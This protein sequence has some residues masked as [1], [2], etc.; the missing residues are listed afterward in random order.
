MVRYRLDDLGWYQF[1]W[2]IQALLKDRVG[3]GV[4]S[5]GGHGDH[6][7]DAWCDGPL[8]F[9]SKDIDTDGPFLFQVK[10]I[11]EA[12][13]V[14]AR[15]A[16]R[17]LDAVRAETKSI[18]RRASAG[19]PLHKQCAHYTLVTNSPVS[20]HDR[21]AA[22]NL[23]KA[24][25]C[26]STVHC[27]C[28]S[29]V[30]DLLD[31][32]PTLRR[33]FP[34]LLSI[35]DLDALLSDVVDREIIQR[36]SAAIAEARDVVPV[37]V[38][39]NAY[40]KAWEVLRKHRFVVLEGPPEMGK[41]A[42]AWM[43]ALA[44]IA[45]GWEGV[46]CDRPDDFFAAYRPGTPQIFIADDAFGR[47]EYDPTRGASWERQLHR[48][49]SRL[50]NSHWLVWTSRKHILERARKQMDLQGLAATF[51][52]PAEVI[53]NASD[54]T[55]REKAL[56]LYRHSKHSISDPRIKD[57]IKQYAVRIVS[58]DAFTPERIRRF[59]IEAAPRLFM[60]V[61]NSA[62]MKALANRI[63]DEISNPTERMRKSL[64]A[65][66]GDHMW[67]LLSLLESDPYCSTKAHIARF[68]KQR[69]QSAA[70]PQQVLEELT[71]A[72]IRL[73]GEEPNRY[74]GWIHPSYRDLI[75]QELGEGGSLKTQ[76]LEGMSIHGVKLALS[77]TGGE[78]GTIRFPLVRTKDDWRLLERRCLEIAKQA[79]VQE[80]AA[81]LTILSNAIDQALVQQKPVLV[82]VLASVCDIVRDS[83][84]STGAEL[85]ADH[86][87]AFG[88]ATIRISPMQLMPQLTKSWQAVVERLR[89]DLRY[90][91]DLP[92]ECPA[93]EALLS[94]SQTIQELEPRVLRQLG[95][96]N[97]LAE[98]WDSLLDR[99]DD[100]L[101]V[102]RSYDSPDAYDGEADAAFAL[103]D[104]LN[105]LVQIM[106]HLKDKAKLR[107]DSLVSH[108][109]RWRFARH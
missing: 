108:A 8:R 109:N 22:V 33:S 57:L 25:L 11:E 49:L 98:I 65:L 71:E 99:I 60:G 42:I 90:E 74:A 50:G 36:S 1:E 72:F 83:W 28:G 17:L 15:P 32:S 104:Y 84:D 78:G 94:V 46:S 63:R 56:I 75:V 80:S 55:T 24:T 12:N 85:A 47:T 9:P 5:W 26:E 100:E 69:P 16:Q 18:A 37:F 102:D 61:D 52:K 59:V 107:I 89:N 20:P 45:S 38:P 62:A 54:L 40:V 10:F 97:A 35:R 79:S 76:F 73:K 92:F 53:V 106:P 51:P 4:E 3:I 19:G 82:R 13:A 66:S 14:G 34:Q 103:A 81:L 105:H 68:E 21:E 48:V 29:D 70:E 27:L 31:L 44:Q 39:T 64:H 86:I 30:C 101:D 77:D 43:I 87:N 58:H 67:M 7:R 23:I 6:G 96:P 88:E 95:F 2:L 91:L 41:T 93:L